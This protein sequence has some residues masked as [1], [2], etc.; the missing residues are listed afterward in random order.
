MDFTAAEVAAIDAGCEVSLHSTPQEAAASAGVEFAASSIYS[1]AGAA[2]SSSGGPVAAFGGQQSVPVPGA[3][4]SGV[5]AKPKKPF[6]VW[7]KHWTLEV[8][9]FHGVLHVVVMIEVFTG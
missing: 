8:G 1:S 6:V 3:V 7:N 9:N 5:G 4:G 2:P